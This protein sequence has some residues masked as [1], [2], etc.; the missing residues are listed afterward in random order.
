MFMAKQQRIVMRKRRTGN[1]PRL[2]RDPHGWGL[3]AGLCA[4]V[5]VLC[6]ALLRQYFGAVLRPAEL[7]VWALF[8][9]VISYGAA[10]CFAVFSARVAAADLNAEQRRAERARQEAA[11]EAAESRGAAPAHDETT[12]PGA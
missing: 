11:R 8:A 1:A 2:N 12:P 4:A 7:L 3:L 10:G 6:I 9:F 5:L